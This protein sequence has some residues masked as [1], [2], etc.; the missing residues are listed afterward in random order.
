[1]LEGVD[2]IG[3]SPRAIGHVAV[4]EQHLG[5]GVGKLVAQILTLVRRC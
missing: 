4:D 5:T 2:R 1:M 3:D